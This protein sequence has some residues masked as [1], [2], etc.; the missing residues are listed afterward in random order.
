MASQLRAPAQ[1][2]CLNCGSHNLQD[3]TIHVKVFC[4]GFIKDVDIIEQICACGHHSLDGGEHFILRKCPFSSPAL[5]SFELC[6]H[7]DLLYHAQ[8]ALLSG[9]HFYTCWT[10]QMRVYEA[11]LDEQQLRGL[12]SLARHF[13]EG[14]MDFVDM[15][16]LPYSDVLRC[17]CERK[18]HY[19]VVDG[20]TLSVPVRRL[21]QTVPW[22]PKQPEPGEEPVALTY[23][24]DYRSRFVFSSKDV[25][26]KLRLLTSAA[27]ASLEAFDSL[28]AL[29]DE[30]E[31]QPLRAAL[32]TGGAG[33]ACIEQQVVKCLPWANAF[34]REL[35]SSSPSC[36]I[37]PLDHLPLLRRWC[38][39][40]CG[41]LAAH[42][43]MPAT[44]ADASQRLL[45]AGWTVEDERTLR[46]CV[47]VIAECLIQV[48]LEA[49]R[50]LHVDMCQAFVDLV[51]QL[52]QVRSSAC[53]P[54]QI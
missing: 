37:A 11:Q 7:W 24:S 3:T 19:L 40:M 51:E 27:G 29:L 47:P 21:L 38:H 26:S 46:R 43:E 50:G 34:L 14:V 23:G 30:P 32:A 35:S 52:C 1:A 33:A 2:Q 20:L 22:L 49:A 10:W 28:V 5:G 6:F 54:L 42:A 36:I 44:V 13:Q 25:R 39:A 18:H 9:N 15:M 31:L 8:R 4:L 16:Q 12:Q 45:D 17:V 41:V 48:R 53:K